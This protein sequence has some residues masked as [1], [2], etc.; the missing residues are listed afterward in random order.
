MRLNQN[1]WK[2]VRKFLVASM[3]PCV[4]NVILLD[5][6]PLKQQVCHDTTYS[7]KTLA[8]IQLKC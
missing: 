3:G 5:I 7:L 8:A 1:L 4:E 6:D 2:T